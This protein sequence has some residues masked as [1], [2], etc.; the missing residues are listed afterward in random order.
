MH[1]HAFVGTQRT[2]SLFPPIGYTGSCM[3][4]QTT[5]IFTADFKKVFEKETASLLRR[6]FGWFTGIVGGIAFLN[7]AVS[8]VVVLTLMGQPVQERAISIAPIWAAIVVHLVVG[9]TFAIAFFIDVKKELDDRMILRATYWLVVLQGSASIVISYM[10]PLGVE[11]ASPTWVRALIT[12]VVTHSVASAFLPWSVRQCL[13]PMYWLVILNAGFLLGVSDLA[14]DDRM[15]I[16]L[17]SPLAGLPGVVICWLRQLRR[18]ERSKFKFLQSRYGEVR[19]ELVDARRLHEALFPAPLADGPVRLSYT[20]EPMR[21][22]GGDFLFARQNDDGVLTVI[23]ADVTGHGIP[24]ALTVNRL[25]GEMERLI[26]EDPNIPPAKLMQG[27][28]RYTHLTLAPHSIYL[29]AFCARIDPAEH[30]LEYVSAGHPPAFIRTVDGRIDEL[31]STT[32]VLGATS[33]DEEPDAGEVRKFSIG[34]GLIAYTDGAIECRD[35]KDSMFGISRLRA[36]VAGDPP[37]SGHWP[38]RVLDCVGGFR[39]GAPK[40][41]T[42]VVEVYRPLH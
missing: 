24:A 9:T 20:Y 22:I 36:L 10:F 2:D 32:I 18:S 29:T 39:D 25:H 42:L 30:S 28:N 13:R 21:Q 4:S 31:E 19:R 14:P 33:G 23:L 1:G 17:L 8:V 6:R 7:A 35:T 15:L 40:D 41:D 5:A 26:G 3:A 12:V 38:E 27:I 16:L 34:D 37:R 11:G